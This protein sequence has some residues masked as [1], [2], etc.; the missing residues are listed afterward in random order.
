MSHLA[1]LALVA[2]VALAPMTTPAHAAGS[3]RC[4]GRI[5]TVLGTEGRDRLHGTSGPDV[6]AG[7]GGADRIEGLG[8]ADV[9]CGGEGADRL[10]GGLGPDR[11]QGNT[12]DDELSGGPQ[13]VGGGDLL[14]GG[15]GDDRLVPGR[16]TD[17]GRRPDQLV[18]T[19]AVRGLV[20]D[21]PAGTATG[22]GSDTIALADD[23]RV[24]LTDFDDVLTGSR[25]R[26]QV[27]PGH[28]QDRIST[29]G[30]R[31]EV[32]FP[33]GDDP[34]AEPADVVNLGSGADVLRH[35][36]GDL[37][38]YAGAGAD[39]VIERG[40]GGDVVFGG[41]GDDRLRTRL[42][43]AAGQEVHGDR[44]RDTLTVVRGSVPG[45]TWDM[46][47]GAA[48]AGEPGTD[49][50]LADLESGILDQSGGTATVSGT[51]DDD[52]IDARVATWFTARGGR[53]RFVGS[54][55][56]DSFEGG[57]GRDSY[58]SDR[59]GAPNACAS[60]EADPGAACSTP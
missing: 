6:I 16:D 53:D 19:G 50:V 21:L 42:S 11:L 54:S 17:P 48:L 15:N 25:W 12:G 44:G 24:V 34:S 51:P 23:V 2:S 38:A 33:S 58:V 1:A 3:E 13:G 20:V 47:T 5:V 36:D 45:L 43:D 56:P 37:T 49:V 60:V 7:L 31:D 46:A 40:T 8:G 55:E 10:R 52:R 35:A 18:W 29:G 9:I 41:A 32:A 14:N 28:G 30:G 39:L 57:S 59:G 22:Q 27:V 4:D 26:D